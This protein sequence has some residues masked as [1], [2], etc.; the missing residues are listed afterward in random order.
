[1]PAAN[2]P[3]SIPSVT[4]ELERKTFMTADWLA[5]SLDSG[6]ITEQQFSTGIDALFMAVSGLVGGGFIDLVTSMQS[7][8]GDDKYVIR[9]HFR[10]PDQDEILTM[11]WT[12]GEDRIIITKRVR[13]AVTGGKVIGYASAKEAAEFF[14]NC[15]RGLRK[16]V[17]L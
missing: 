2:S 5:R 8:C 9:R 13:G 17:E 6:R 7:F 1:M 11:A 3:L 10:H 15:E 14:R 16:W 12:L 4:Q